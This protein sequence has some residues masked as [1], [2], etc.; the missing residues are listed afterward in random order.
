MLT[1]DFLVIVMGVWFIGV[2]CGILFAGTV[3]I[4]RR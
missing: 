3:G 1:P 2:C 4:R